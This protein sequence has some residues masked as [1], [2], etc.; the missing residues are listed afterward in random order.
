M[1]IQW[2]EPFPW[3]PLLIKQPLTPQIPGRAGKFEDTVFPGSALVQR[4]FV[5]DPAASR[6]LPSCSGPLAE[7]PEVLHGP[8]WSCSSSNI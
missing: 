7:G 3:G 4:P 8:S 6:V 1:T 2:A 5:L